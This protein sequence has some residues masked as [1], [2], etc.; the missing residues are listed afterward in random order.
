[1][2]ENEFVLNFRTFNALLD[3]ILP[4]VKESDINF[5][6]IS[7]SIAYKSISYSLNLYFSDTIVDVVIKLKD[8][9]RMPTVN[10]TNGNISTGVYRKQVHNTENSFYLM[11]T[12]VKHFLQYGK[13]LDFNV[14]DRILNALIK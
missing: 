4:C 3:R 11:Q 8:Y 13:I 7:C 6:D 2:L 12:K 10:T 5:T 1:M 14:F 9:E